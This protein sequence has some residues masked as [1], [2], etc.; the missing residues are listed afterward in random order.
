M[1]LSSK[2]VLLPSIVLLIGTVF[3]T[4]ATNAFA[5]DDPFKNKVEIDTDN[6]NK[7]SCDESQAGHNTAECVIA[8][9]LTTDTF[10]LQGEK[11]KISLD[12]Q[13]E[14]QNDC[15][16]SGDG[17]NDS[18]CAIATNKEIGPIDILETLP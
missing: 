11:N 10:T 2:T 6:E 18:I 13:Q 17:N 9:N 5:A 1:N 3:G 8:D 14:N 4:T 15:D 7:N 16:E 12:L